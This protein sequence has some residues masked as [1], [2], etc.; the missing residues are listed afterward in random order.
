[1]L[2]KPGAAKRL[3]YDFNPL[4]GGPGFPPLNRPQ[5][6]FFQR[7]VATDRIGCKKRIAAK[8]K[9]DGK[10]SCKYAAYLKPVWS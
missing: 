4:E 1:M 6:G 8:N 2:M 9:R 3:S 7:D 10:S 5:G